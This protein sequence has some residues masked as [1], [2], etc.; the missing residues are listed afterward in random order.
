MVMGWL[1]SRLKEFVG[2][3]GGAPPI[4]L[5][6]VPSLRA[7]GIPGVDEPME[8]DDCYIELYLESLQLERAR[9]FGTRFQGV[10][11][12]FVTLPRE[13]DQRAQLTA[14]SKPE[15]LAELDKNSIDRVITVSKQLMSA[16]A[17]RGNPVSLE[18]GLFS[19]KSGNV[20]TA[21]LEYV[22]RVSAT[23]GISFVGAIKPFVPLITEGMDLIAGQVQDTAL[24]VGV[25][26]DLTLT[27]GRVAAIIACPKGSIEPS[28]LSLLKDGSLLLDGE[29]LK[30]AYATFS[31]RRAP[32]KT[33]Y[34]EIPELRERFAAV[35]AGI[36]SH[37]E[38]DARDALTAFRLAALASPD[39]ISSDARTLVRN[40]KQKVDEA[41]PPGGFAAVDAAAMH[42]LK[43]SDIPLYD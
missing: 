24:E 20:V 28:K 7:E 37:K 42:D 5:T 16:T 11:Y 34:G 30:C 27:K 3:V 1:G 2:K 15:Q 18:F 8:P 40:L 26:T 4:E 33:D 21:F 9:V 25:D 13:G 43:L 41:F 19:V 23:A 10:A 29:P 17:F 12:S 32:R 14:V 31:L 36:R 6:F 22:T 38:K 39:L 35:L